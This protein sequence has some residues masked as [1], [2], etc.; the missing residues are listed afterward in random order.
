MRSI[1]LFSCLMSSF[2]GPVTS[3]SVGS[4]VN[5]SVVR[6][7]STNM[8]T[9]S[10]SSVD[11]CRCLAVSLQVALCN[12]FDN[13]TCHL[14]PSLPQPF[15][16]ETSAGARLFLLSALPPPPTLSD[17]IV[18]L[19][20][21]NGTKLNIVTPRCLVFD[22]LGHLVTI[23]TMV[24]SLD[25]YEASSLSLIDQTSLP[26]VYPLNLAFNNGA[27]YMSSFFGHI[28]IMDST[29]LTVIGQISSSNFVGPRDMIF[30]NG[31][32]TM[33]V[34]S[35]NDNTLV[36]FNRSSNIS[37]DFTLVSRLAFSHAAPHGLWRVNDQL[38]YVT[39]YTNSSILSYSENNDTSWTEKVVVQPQ[40]TIANASGTHVTVDPSHRLWF[41]VEDAGVL[42]FDQQ[43]VLLSTFTYSSLSIYDL[44]IT[45]ENIVYLSAYH[46]NQLVR[47]DPNN[48]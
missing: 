3:I 38:F 2:V 14:F 17:L 27:F 20:E 18:K 1:L 16:I 36:F 43:G 15:R 35:T 24:S 46:S 44:L 41:S 48:A 29:N 31:G 28:S 42:V 22:D 37:V 19:N 40:I 23:R 34:A 4:I 13:G 25:R 8:T 10:V 45:G 26:N 5:A 12:W 7:S 32:M 30:I 39:S 9:L 21:T 33:I 11:Q 47:L 6:L